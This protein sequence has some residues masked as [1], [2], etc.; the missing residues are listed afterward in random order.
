MA[1][2]KASPVS[3]HDHRDPYNRWAAQVFFS[4]SPRRSTGF[5]GEPYFGKESKR[6][7]VGAVRQGWTAWAVW[8]LQL[9]TLS[10]RGPSG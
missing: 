8:L 6:R 4:R 10:R 2:K 5:Q 7:R 9:A 3:R 1:V